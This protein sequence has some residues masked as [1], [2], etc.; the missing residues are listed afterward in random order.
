MEQRN[1][2]S[3]FKER[4]NI[5]ILRLIATAGKRKDVDC[6]NLTHFCPQTKDKPIYA[7]VSK[8]G[9]V[10]LMLDWHGKKNV[11]DSAVWQLIEF[12]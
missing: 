12:A 10:I 9:V 5:D 6:I 3:D 4:S 2:I 7:F 1:F 8:D 11:Q